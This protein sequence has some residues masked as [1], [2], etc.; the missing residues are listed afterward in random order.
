MAFELHATAAARFRE[1]ESSGAARTVAAH[2][3]RLVSEGDDFDCYKINACR[4]A[5]ATGASKLEAVRGLLFATRLGLVDL[6]WDIHCPSCLGLPAFHRHL[7]QLATRAHCPLCDVRWD[8]DLQDQVEVTFTVNPDVRPVAL[9]DFAERRWPDD[10]AV[11]TRR[12]TRDDRLPE[13]ATPIEPGHAFAV[14]GRLA[15]GDYQCVTPGHPEGAALLHVAGDAVAEEQRLALALA[16]DG[17]VTPRQLTARPGPARFAVANAFPR[18]WGF[19]V[20]PLE[21]PRHWVSATYVTG[22]QDFRD[23]FS[24]EFLAPDVSFAIRSTTLLFTDIKGSTEM[25]ERLG[26]AAAYALVQR[27]FGLMTDVI[28]RREGGVVKTIGD[29]VM[30]SFGVNRD[31]VAA[32][33]EIQEG[34][35]RVDPPLSQIEVKIG[36]HRG[37][38]IAVTSNRMLDFFGRTVNL[39]AR[40]QG[41]S[42]AGEVLLSEAVASDPAVAELLR[43][44]GLTSGRI[45]ATLKGI[46]HPVRLASLRIRPTKESA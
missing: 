25:Y 32:A 15:A 21:T 26:D 46:P 18:T 33:L 11:Y 19:A 39:A 27:H 45:E 17:V 23:L 5:E 28:R 2:L 1:L 44:R 30:A 24:G 6:T 37:P 42:R 22:L 34:F 36:L 13:M 14:T 41:H 12:L 40:V 35:A 31:A 4:L 43:E 3:R 7:M 8:L 29:A 10:A 9:E 38:T 20:R 16:A